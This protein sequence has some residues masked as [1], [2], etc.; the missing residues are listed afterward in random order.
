[1][2]PQATVA[3]LSPMDISPAHRH[4]CG[5]GGIVILDLFGGIA[6]ALRGALLAG[7]LIKGYYIVEL[8]SDTRSMAYWHARQLQH[9]FPALLP[10]QVVDNMFYL[11]CNVRDLDITHLTKLGRVDMLMASWP[12]QGLSR[13]NPVGQ[14]LDDERSG[15]FQELL[16]IRDLA[17]ELYPAMRFVAEN[18]VFSETHPHDWAHVCAHFGQPLVFDAACISYSHRLRAYWSNFLPAVPPATDPT[19]L[20]A[21]ILDADH[22]PPVALYSDAAPMGQFDVQGQLRTKLPTIM[23]SERTRSMLQGHGKV[24][25]RSTGQLVVPSVGELERALGFATGATCGNPAA[26]MDEDKRRRALGNVVVVHVLQ[27]IFSL[28]RL[29]GSGQHEEAGVPAQLREE[30]GGLPLALLTV[31]REQAH[32]QQQELL[33]GTERGAIPAGATVAADRVASPPEVDA[34]RVA[35]TPGLQN[36]TPDLLALPML[37]GTTQLYVPRD[38]EREMPQEWP[39][40]PWSP[41]QEGDFY[42]MT[43]AA[44]DVRTQCQGLFCAAKYDGRRGVPLKVQRQLVRLRKL[45]PDWPAP[46]IQPAPWVVEVD[47]DNAP[48]DKEAA[49]VLQQLEVW[50]STI[51]S[52]Q[53]SMTTKRLAKVCD[54][55]HGLQQRY[56]ILLRERI[57]GRVLGQVVPPAPLRADDP[58]LQPLVAQAAVRQSRLQPDRWFPLDEQGN[59][60]SR[61]NTAAFRSAGTTGSVLQSTVELQY[62]YVELPAQDFQARNLPS[63]AAHGAALSAHFDECERQGFIE[64]QDVVFPQRGG[65]VP[66]PDFVNLITPLG[67][68]DKKDGDIR[69]VVDSTQSGLNATLAPWPM[70]LPTMERL[71]EVVP[72]GYVLGKRDLRHGF[73][74][75]LLC[76]RDRRNLGFRH[77]VSG[78]IGR[79]AANPFGVS[80]APGR[81]WDFSLE[82]ARIAYKRLVAMGFTSVIL[83]VYVD[84]FVLAAP[85]HWQLRAIFDLLNAMASELG[86]AWKESKDV[87]YDLP[88]YSLE[89]LGLILNTADPNGTTVTLP[90]DKYVKYLEGLSV[91]EP[92]QVSGEEVTI[93]FRP[94]LTTIGQLGWASKALRWGRNYMG[95][96]WELL[97]PVSRRHPEF[98]HLPGW[99]DMAA[100]ADDA[101]GESV[102]ILLQHIAAMD[103]AM[104]PTADWSLGVELAP[105]L[106][107]GEV[108]DAVPGG[109]PL[110]GA[111]TPAARRSRLPDFVTFKVT[112]DLL[113]DLRFWRETLSGSKPWNGILRWE[114]AVWDMVKGLHYEQQAT[115]AAKEQDLAGWGAVLGV[116]RARGEFSE[117][118]RHLSICWLELL[119]IVRG[120]QQWRDQYRHKRVLVWSDNTVAV[121]AINKGCSHRV[122]RKIMQKLALYC[123]ANDVQIRAK[124]IPGALNM[125]ADALSRQR[126]AASVVSYTISPAVFRQ[127]P[128]S[129]HQQVTCFMFCD[130]ARL[131]PSMLLGAPHK[132]PRSKALCFPPSNSV[133]AG[134]NWRQLVGQTVYVDP[135]WDLIPLTLQVLQQAWRE[136]PNGT[137]IA[138]LL[139]HRPDRSWFKAA[140]GKQNPWLKVWQHWRREQST[141]VLAAVSEV[142][143]WAAS[144]RQPRRLPGPSPEDL[145]LAGSCNWRL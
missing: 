67:C 141:G 79:Y 135:P 144:G 128:W 130:E 38:A 117:R 64:Y 111:V 30:A 44:A 46:D 19:R 66:H 75:L 133:F 8:D 15:L 31:Q 32:P 36:G 142:S 7:H 121:A 65:S 16:R 83:M 89:A 139:P 87:G 4:H 11:P 108:A 70:R 69:V 68:V 107:A 43:D 76:E 125:E 105:H 53:D 58:S 6:S 25:H 119:A 2:P 3:S 93:P 60:R 88:T 136:D 100:I 10:Q 124:H 54:L 145:L 35:A 94:L 9:E 24:L 137:R 140:L 81:F 96:L 99:V 26:H 17:M 59:L 84:D 1:M 138:I 143:Q 86:I 57:P 92:V 5:D 97:L 21:N 34:P 22:A 72:P 73:H 45:L 122:G 116:E 48:V 27:W 118:E 126:M 90:N 41:F 33:L 55:A 42:S 39:S 56:G 131:V 95:S 101:W 62:A 109:R 78:R 132:G 102:D 110:A 13:A 104:Q 85:T 49:E 77:P 28:L 106:D 12:C 82:I 74:H 103:Q 123:I 115:D 98:Q 18:V 23:A 37:P 71:I 127:A 14:G 50:M 120:L 112:P 61:L 113:S 47:G 40:G 134:E 51:K 80:Q 91:L 20:L 52:V 114:V 29:P 63:C 129:L